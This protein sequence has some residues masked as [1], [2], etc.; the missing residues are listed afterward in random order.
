[1]KF[2]EY[3][4]KS[5]LTNQF[6]DI[7][8][9]LTSSIWNLTETIGM[10][11]RLF[12]EKGRHQN[13]NEVEHNKKMAE[14]LG[15]ILW[16]V[17]NAAN[18]LDL[19]LESVALDN[20]EKCNKR[21]GNKK[22]NLKLFDD[23]YPVDQQLPRKTSFRIDEDDR[24]K[25]RV[26]ID[27]KDGGSIQLGSRVTDNSFSDDGYRF[28]D[29]IHLS[30]MTILGW[31]PVMRSLLSRKRK[32]NPVIDEVEDGARAANLEEAVSAM[33]Y[34]QASDLDYFT[35]EKYVPF[36]LLKWIERITRSLEVSNATY[37]LWNEAIITGYSL[38]RETYKNKGGII[39]VDLN[40]RQ[41]KYRAFKND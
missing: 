12:D 29:V 32:D 21:W 15:D 33:I 11:S 28:H 19:E 10:L 20:I 3:Q 22:S 1:M 14:K 13:I 41:I 40:K 39:D 23:G 25:V 16:Y 34:E 8:R 6:V 27:L 26:S 2:N 38:W 24:G 35:R 9:S 36:D 4:E 37:E 5:K 7:E 18:C 17:S 31:S 30:F